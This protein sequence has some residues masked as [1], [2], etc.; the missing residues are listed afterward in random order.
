MLNVDVMSRRL[1]QFS[2]LFSCAGLCAGL[3]CAD[4]GTA[5]ATRSI[6]GGTSDPGQDE[7]VVLVFTLDAN[8]L[9]TA[10]CSGELISPHVVLTVA[11]C[12][13]A[14]TAEGIAGDQVAFA[15]GYDDQT[16]ALDNP[17]AT[18]TMV[19][20]YV[21]PMFDADHP[22]DGYDLALLYLDDAAPAGV[23]P[24]A[25]NRYRLLAVDEGQPL[26]LI[27]FGT[28]EGGTIQPSYDRESAFSTLAGFNDLFVTY[29]DAEHNTCQ[30]DSGGPQLMVLDGH[31]VIV[32]ITSFGPTACDGGSQSTR[33][34]SF[35]AEIEVNV[36]SRDPQTQS[37][38]GMDGVCGQNCPAPDPDC[39]CAADGFCT[40]ACP[41]PDMDPD[42][43]LNCG[44]DGVCQRSS[45]CPEPDPDCGNRTAGASCGQDS[46]CASGH[47]ALTSDNSARVCVD[48][49]DAVG[50]CPSDYDCDKGMNPPL[51]IQ[52]RSSCLLSIAPGQ[53]ATGAGT[54]W[55]V[56]GG[57]GLI[58]ATASRRRRTRR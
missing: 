8:G 5:Q 20:Y 39:P 42:C 45:D 34:D 38:C 56:L 3:A 51:C 15:D 46:D 37:N 40:S 30:G 23:T 33:I 41:T 31:E 50:N 49:C 10:H 28:T 24:M 57:V 22:E 12:T 17:L 43:P 36:A 52:Q 54:G 29:G 32:G 6:I 44:A 11:H 19:D 4:P 58:L 55:L 35:L 14:N 53:G 16:G 18:R 1:A 47:C 27:G 48:E 25:L 13:P 7:A 9:V 21:H 26:R 2:M